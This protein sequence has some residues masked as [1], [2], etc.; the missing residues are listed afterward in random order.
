M[1]KQSNFKQKVRARM[2]KTGERYAAARKALLDQA[3]KHTS[4]SSR[5]WIAQ[6]DISDESV[7][8]KTGKNLD[9]WCDI[10]EAWDGDQNDHTAVATYLREELNVDSWWA[11][12]ITVSFERITGKRLPY[13]QKDGTFTANKS[14][15]LPLLEAV[16]RQLF[17]SDDGRD[18]LF[19]NQHT[20][21]LS[22]PDAKNLRIKLEPGTA[23]IWTEPQK[24]GKT[25]L[26]V[27]HEKLPTF[28]DVEQWKFYWEEL[29]A[30]IEE[31]SN[32]TTGK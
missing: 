13:Q 31:S 18:D 29:M 9:E 22:K 30:A 25:K 20:E 8:T 24:S 5:A 14:K 26:T 28:D 23:L 11:Q 6:P 17:L 21:L 16:L 32:G 19:P 7:I 3:S 4:S 15:V 1:T 12:G 2:L 27:S 10:I